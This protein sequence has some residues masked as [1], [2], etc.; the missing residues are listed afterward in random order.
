MGTHNPTD[1][2]DLLNE[3]STEFT[4]QDYDLKKLIRWIVLSRPYALSSRA[5]PRN[6]AD[7][8]NRGNTPLFSR[9][10][11]RQMRP[12]ELYRSMATLSYA[13]PTLDRLANHRPPRDRWLR[14]FTRALGND[15]GD[16]TSSFNG[17]IPQTLM[18]FHGQLVQT[19][20]SDNRDSFLGSLIEND[21]LSFNQVVDRMFWATLARKP[22]GK[23]RRVATQLAKR[24]E[25]SA[26]DARKE[27]LQDLWWA[28]LNSNEFILNH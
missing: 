11:L 13:H 15:Q 28:L 5:G 2:E 16:E 20:V 23:E 14:Q 12:E 26:G 9:F 3:M 1:H 8:P 24:R 21:S 22:T 25:A 27:A 18:M 6:Q 7:E 19:A 4:R 17:T 10:Y